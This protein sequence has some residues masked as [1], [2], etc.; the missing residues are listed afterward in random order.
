MFAAVLNVLV[1]V[2]QATSLNHY[3][4]QLY[5]LAGPLNGTSCDIIIRSLAW[6][7]HVLNNV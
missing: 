5:S 2:P 6:K 1:A 3:F 4:P 7:L